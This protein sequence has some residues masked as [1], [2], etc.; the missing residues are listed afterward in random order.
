MKYEIVILKG[1]E[2]IV[3]VMIKVSNFLNDIS[4]WG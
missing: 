3:P 2:I 4:A 1:N